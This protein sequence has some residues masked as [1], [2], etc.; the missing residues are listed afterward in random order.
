MRLVY[1]WFE[2]MPV[3][4]LANLRWQYLANLAVGLLGGLYLLMLG[5]MYSPEE[6]GLYSVCLAIA[7]IIFS[8]TDFRLQEATIKFVDPN[9]QSSSEAR[10]FAEALF[11]L[12]FIAKFGS[13]FIG[14]IVFLNFQYIL[15][16]ENSA[17][18]IFVLCIA[19]LA[20]GKIGNSVAIGLIRSAE[21][22]N[23]HA[24]ILAAEWS[25]RL[26]LTAIAIF[27]F[28]VSLTFALFISV[29]VSLASN[30]TMLILGIKYSHTKIRWLFLN[31]RTQLA[32]L[33]NTMRNFV[34][35][36]YGISLLEN[37][38][39]EADVAVVA[40]FL[41]LPLVGIYKMTKS[42]AL[43]IWK[44]ADPVFLVIMPVLV[45]FVRD[46]DRT[47]LIIF[48]RRLSI[49][50][51]AAACIIIIVAAV[52]VPYIVDLFLGSEYVR[53]IGIFPIMM[54]WILF[55]LPL[56]WVH[57]YAAAIGRPSLQL[58]GSGAGNALLLLLLIILTPLFGLEGAAVS[59]SIGLGATFVA[60]FLALRQQNAF[61][62]E[63]FEA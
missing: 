4:F 62:K 5:R 55:S 54:G 10:L 49:M 21:R 2:S 46:G 43:M 41:P 37:M 12:D 61:K 22:F 53:I 45:R 50:L 6:F 60:S 39:K 44:A 56:I 14:V 38:A 36:S 30:V 34:L 35:P 7:T 8:F 48:L 33:L 31:N 13:T 17:Q 63:I 9:A 27:A 23:V 24:Q 29:L 11:T 47:G 52:L 1:R 19:N 18:F 42:L 26:L 20:V 25:A 15:P 28:Q 57:A 40:L 59:W 16:A 58:I 3:G 32:S 51:A